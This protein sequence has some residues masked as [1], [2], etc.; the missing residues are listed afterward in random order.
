MTREHWLTRW[1]HGF[2]TGL[3]ITVFVVLV[4]IVTATTLSVL[5]TLS[6]KS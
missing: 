5:T 2:V 3:G 6:I 1:V 4:L